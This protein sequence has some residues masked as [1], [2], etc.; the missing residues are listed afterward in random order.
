MKYL[1]IVGV[2][3]LVGCGAKSGAPKDDPSKVAV[4]VLDEIVHNR[5]GQAWATLH[6]ADQKVA[7]RGEYVGCETRSPVLALPTSVRVVDVKHESVGLGDGTFVDS[8]AVDLR[9]GFMGGFHLMHAVHLVATKGAWRW[10]LPPDRYRAYRADRCPTDAGSTP[11][12]S[13][14]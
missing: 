5:Y 9:I 2:I 4:G 3:L 11:P 12:A 6:P 7:S 13:T 1:A 10:I 14:S 8:T